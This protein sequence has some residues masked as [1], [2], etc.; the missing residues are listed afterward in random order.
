MDHQSG[1]CE[2]FE[3]LSQQMYQDYRG[4]HQIPTMEGANIIE[5]T[6]SCIWDVRNDGAPPDETVCVVAWSLSPH[7]AFSHAQ[8]V[9]V[10]VWQTRE[11]D[12]WS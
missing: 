12:A 9:A 8:A 1:E 4:G 7:G 11:E 10:A 5:E 2:A 3:R 6:G